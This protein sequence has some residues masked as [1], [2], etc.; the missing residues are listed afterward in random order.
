MKRRKNW[1]KEDNRGAALISIMIAVAFISILASAILYMSYNNYQM[2]VINYQ[3]KVNFYG[4]E[5]DMTEVSTAIRN[6]IADATSDP[7]Q[8]L[9]AA[10]GYNE[11]S[12]GIGRYDLAKLAGYVYPDAAI[13]ASN[14]G[15]SFV[16]ADNVSVK[17][18]TT[19]SDTTVPNVIYSKDSG[20]GV[21]TITLKGL[22]V[23]HKDLED[24]TEHSITTDLVYKIQ[25]KTTDSDAGGI[26]E[27]SMMMDSPINVG[28]TATKM[29]IY[30]NTFIGPGTYQ[31]N[32]SGVVDPA[33]ADALLLTDKST[34]IQKGEYMVV[35]GNIHLSG[36]AVLQV[37]SGRLTVFGDIIVE[38]NAKF[39][40]TGELYMPSGENPH[41]M[42]R[43]YQVRAA[44][45]SNVI[46]SEYL[47]YLD[48][49]CPI[50]RISPESY[51][52]MV[53]A[54]GLDDINNSED[55]D[56]ILKQI[57]PTDMYTY[58]Y[59]ISDATN[60]SQW[61]DYYGVQYRVRSTFQSPI[62]SND[63]LNSLVFLSGK[64]SSYTFQDG[65][66]ISN[67]TYISMGGALASNGKTIILT[68]LGGDVFNTMLAKSTDDSAF[69]SDNTHKFTMKSDELTYAVT[70]RNDSSQEF[71]IGDCFKPQ[72]NETVNQIL[73]YATDGAAGDPIV[74][75]A[76]GYDQ[77]TKE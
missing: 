36:D 55:D 28:G 18:S 23:E 59:G 60:S 62:N 21:E 49:D 73:G 25:T 1:L 35:F 69:F 38:G 47:N 76:V 34:V 9:K 19:V 56:G 74:L 17:F 6:E 61:M 57:I 51:T 72:A 15:V 7:Y 14:T 53:T 5:S 40:C 12:T 71:Y 32:G 67:S 50:K 22:K 44:V 41:N 52:Q 68:Q 8:Q 16:S 63:N 42:N 45:Q 48:T 30:G 70:G 39:L 75:T 10:I 11:P 3:S 65:M 2:K 26:G 33:A 29:V 20:T 54:L 43:P 64:Q 46:P 4:T 31:Y 27:F 77:W 37:V 13:T 58:M 24:G 66:A